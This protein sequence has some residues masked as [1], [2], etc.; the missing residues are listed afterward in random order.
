VNSKARQ[1]KNKSIRKKGFGP[2]ET[3]VALGISRDC[4]DTKDTKYLR[5]PQS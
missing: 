2:R 4:K 5:F 1:L 3:Q